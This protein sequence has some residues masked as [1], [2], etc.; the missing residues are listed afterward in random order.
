[1]LE[2]RS[3]WLCM[4]CHTQQ[5]ATRG[6]SA[7]SFGICRLTHV[8]AYAVPRY[9][10]VEASGCILPACGACLGIHAIGNVLVMRWAQLR[11]RQPAKT[12]G[13]F[14]M[15]YHAH[16]RQV[17]RLDLRENSADAGTCV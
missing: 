3:V 12:W 14:T 5:D 17:C 15:P 4:Q 6:K 16:A 10:Y 11:S 1:M 9:R 7:A 2:M 8:W 13:K